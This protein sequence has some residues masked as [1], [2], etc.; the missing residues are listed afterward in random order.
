MQ[1]ILVSADLGP[2]VASL[3]CMIRGQKTGVINTAVAEDQELRCRASWSLLAAG[4][5]AG[6]VLGGIHGTSG[7]PL[8]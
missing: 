2:K 3:I 7:R 1:G 4:W 6:T 5:D 8:A